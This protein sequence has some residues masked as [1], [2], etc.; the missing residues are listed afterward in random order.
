MPIAQELPI[1][2]NAS[3]MTMAEEIFGEGVQV[4]SADY[5]GDRRSSGTYSDGDTISAET[6]PGDTGVILSTGR[7]RDYTNSSNNWWGGGSTNTNQASNTSTNTRGV[8]NDAAFNEAAGTT[9]YDASIL[10][11][12]FIPTGDMMTIQFVFS[13]E[14]YPEYTDSLYQDFIGI[15]INGEYVQLGVGDGDI[16]PNNINSGNNESL[17]I[18]N[19]NDEYN[20]EMD[21][22]TA[23]M[24]LT[25]PVNSG[26]V[27]TLRIGIADVTD[28]RYDSTLLIAGGSVQTALV[29]EDDVVNIAPDGSQVVDLMANDDGPSGATLTLTHINGQEVSAGDVITFSTGQQI[30]INGDGTVTVLADG[31]EESV[32]FSYTTSVDGSDLSDTA[33]V[34]INQVPCF[35]AGTR[36][37]TPDGYVAVDDLQAGD[38]V[39]T[40]DDGVQPISWIGSR[41]V[42]GTGDFA[43]IHIRK[44]TFGHHRALQLSPLHRVLVRD[45]LSEILFGTAEVLVAVKEL[46]NGHSVRQIPTDHVTYVHL[47]FD[48]HQ[49]VW[50]EGLETES[51]LPGPQIVN[52]FEQETMAEICS[53]FPELDPETGAGYGKAARRTLR[54]YEANLLIREQAVA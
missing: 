34:T 40:K 22:F 52:S 37:R 48:K 17:F 45:G 29:A 6:T 19:L 51:F 5:S 24:T 26:D 21:G 43:P 30:Q 23:T 18:S 49:I 28:S 20:T 8:D 2:L 15:W 4:V 50:A 10:E 33:F 38:L 41:E 9:T 14:E 3:A 13:S 42:E 46:I 32:N 11:M 44:N 27:N 12:E 54:G 7:A 39:V 25:M 16:D 31:D 35:V 36:V 53:I 47:M 1:D